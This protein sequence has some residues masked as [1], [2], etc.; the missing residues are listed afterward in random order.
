MSSCP[1]VEQLRQLL[2]EQ[3]DRADEARIVVH[4]QTCERC[5]DRLDEVLRGRAVNLPWLPVPSAR[6]AEAMG[7]APTAIGDMA[8]DLARSSGPGSAGDTMPTDVATNA[9]AAPTE[10]EHQGRHDSPGTNR[11]EP[12]EPHATTDFIRP[13]PEEY[14][15]ADQ[16]E[17]ETGQTTDAGP[18]VNGDETVSQTGPSSPSPG[19]SRA[20]PRTDGLKIPGYEI[21]EKLG[22]GGM[23]V[24]YKARQPG[25]N[26]LVALEDD[27]S[28]GA[29][30]GR[31][32]S[33][34][35]ASRPRRSPGCGI[36]TSSRSTTSAKWTACRSC[37]WSCSRAA[38]S[39]IGWRARPSR[40]GEAAE[41][42]AT[43]A[44]AVQAA[45]EAG[46]IH[47]DLKPS[48]ILFT[49]DGVPKITDFGLAKRLES[50]SRQTETGQI[51]GSPSYMAPEQARGHTRD[52]GPAA[53][54]YALGAIL[55][56]ML[57]GRPPFKGET[58]IE[59]VRQVIHDEPVPPV[60]AGAAGRP[61]PRDHLPE[62]PEQGAAQAVRVGRRVR[63]RP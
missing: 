35:S 23:G 16:F 20:R 30:R 2:D 43:L 56:E 13:S 27:P 7:S 8:V 59:T 19:E 24:V 50:D 51:M 39:T 22:E 63:R 44:R 46:I 21:L 53:D 14:I 1:S 28:A 47:R 17:V 15:L 45:H 10:V 42:M 3:L 55:Y 62:M 41:L 33:R 26:R 60:A 49:A 38:T 37:R 5:Q 57:T 34:G 52:V 40:A 61:R 18:S 31:I 54:V 36:P 4:V 32:T 6:A 9:A 11:Q 29:R 48:N 12:S 25:L 58:P